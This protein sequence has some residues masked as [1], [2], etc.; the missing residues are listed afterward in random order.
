MSHDKRT[1]T[2]ASLAGKVSLNPVVGGM[3][4]VAMGLCVPTCGYGPVSMKSLLS[5]RS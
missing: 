5:L 4:D 1:C 2:D 3:Y